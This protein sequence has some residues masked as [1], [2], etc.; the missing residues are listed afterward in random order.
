[1]YSR[2]A[3]LLVSLWEAA[4]GQTPAEVPK[5]VGSLTIVLRSEAAI[6]PPVLNAME[7]EVE[8]L[9]A[10]SGIRIAWVLDTGELR[11][12]ERFAILTLRGVCRLDAPLPAATQMAKDVIP[13]G[14]TQVADGQ[15]LPFADIRCD[16]IRALVTR[17]LFARPS[18]QREGLLGRAIGRVMAHELYHVLLRTRSHGKAGLARPA[19]SS[20]DLIGDTDTFAP[21]DERKLSWLSG[22]S[23]IASFDA[24]R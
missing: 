21:S 4:A 15:V 18:N 8:S 17:E 12:S 10:P 24:V 20:A 3:L 22:E 14:Q 2:A 5:L 6:S 1:M 19:Q 11:P 16:P 9:A 23:K 7:R 13:L